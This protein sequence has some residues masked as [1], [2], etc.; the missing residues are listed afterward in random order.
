MLILLVVSIFI[1]YI[2]RGNLSIAAPLVSAEIGLSPEQLGV[3]LSSFFWT[4]A[5]LQLFG[6][7]G[8]LV[9]R[10]DVYRVYG[11]AFLLWSVATAVTGLVSGFALLLTF[12]LILGLGESLAYPVYS[13]IL[14]SEYEEHQRGVANSLIDAGSKLGPGIGTL[15]GGLLM[16]QY[17]WRAFFIALGIGSLIWL[18]PWYRNMPKAGHASKYSTAGPK[19]WVILRRQEAWATFVG[20]FCANYFWYFLLTWLPS[21][22]VMER[23]FTMQSM[24]STGAIAYFAIAISTTTMGWLSDR[25]I[26]AGASPMRVRRNLTAIGLAGST[27][28]LPV[29]VVTDQNMSTALLILACLSY[30][31]YTSSHWAITQTLAGSTAAAKWT[32]IQNGV[33]NLAGV[34]A[35]WLTG[36]I[37]QK[38]GIFYLAF[39]VAAVIVLTGS[40]VYFF[41]I[42]RARPIDWSTAS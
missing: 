10:F 5:A 25:W 38:T 12:R 35:P 18:L 28:I 20:L 26:G 4:Y 2:D 34:A 11:V 3:L 27:A 24:A 6:V 42:G 37:V 19:V 7:A 17:G 1:N 40:A 39:L 15:F 23:H 21:Y 36:F 8:W 30:G 14:A 29:C 13:R 22:L 41:W 32:G 16:A 31:I 33:G 9:D